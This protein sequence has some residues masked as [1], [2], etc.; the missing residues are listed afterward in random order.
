MRLFTAIHKL[1]SSLSVTAGEM[2]IGA[3]IASSYL[4][5]TGPR[6]I[7]LSIACVNA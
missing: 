2:L 4:G 6:R 3:D 1:D 7:T 5:A